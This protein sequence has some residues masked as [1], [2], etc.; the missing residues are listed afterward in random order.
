MGGD[1]PAGDL[2]PSI[3]DNFKTGGSFVMVTFAQAYK[4]FNQAILSTLDAE[5]QVVSEIANI[6]DKVLPALVPS[7]FE[8]VVENLLVQTKNLYLKMLEPPF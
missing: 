5:K 6:F 4:G 1:A 7:E 2:A 3:S 8:N